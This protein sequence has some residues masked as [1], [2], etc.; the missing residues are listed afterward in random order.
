MKCFYCDDADGNS[1]SPH[2]KGSDDTDDKEKTVMGIF[3]DP[4]VV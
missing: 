1:N 3:L 4:T 2:Q